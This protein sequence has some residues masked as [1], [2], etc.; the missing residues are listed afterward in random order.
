MAC[1][2]RKS[3][4]PQFCHSDEGG[5]ESFARTG[6]AI[7]HNQNHLMRFL[8]RRTRELRSNWRSN[9]KTKLTN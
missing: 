9:D 3:K 8:L 5:L 6:E 7:S 4:L 1:L 2:I